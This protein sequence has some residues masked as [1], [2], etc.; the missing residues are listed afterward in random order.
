MANLMPESLAQE[1]WSDPNA[2]L[3]NGPPQHAAVTPVDGGY[4][5]TGRWNFSSGSRH[6]TWVVAVARNGAQAAAMIR[7]A[8]ADARRRGVVFQNTVGSGVLVEGTGHRHL[9]AREMRTAFDGVDVVGVCV[10]FL[11]C[12]LLLCCRFCCLGLVVCICC[13][14]VLLRY[15]EHRILIDQKK[16]SGSGL[17]T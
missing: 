15:P 10:L 16:L 2:I 13:C 4:Q 11:C 3:S 1:I 8:A 14:G 5:L 17:K 6:A 7:R 12:C 9:D